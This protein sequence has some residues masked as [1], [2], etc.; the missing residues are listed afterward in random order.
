MSYGVFVGEDLEGEGGSVLAGGE[1]DSRT[2]KRVEK[3]VE[4]D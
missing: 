4:R 3:L 1:D 2:R